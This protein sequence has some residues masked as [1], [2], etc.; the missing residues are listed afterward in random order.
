MSVRHFMSSLNVLVRICIA[1]VILNF[2]RSSTPILLQNTPISSCIQGSNT[3]TG[4][5]RLPVSKPW[6]YLHLSPLSQWPRRKSPHISI[7][8]PDPEAPPPPPP[9]APSPCEYLH[10]SP[11]VQT[12]RLKSPHISTPEPAESRLAAGG[13]GGTAAA[14]APGS[15]PGAPGARPGM[16]GKPG[17]SPGMPGVKTGG[18]AAGMPA[19]N[20]PGSGAAKPYICGCC[21][22][23]GG[24]AP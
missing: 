2:K 17:I 6:E 3:A 8:R 9:A 7:R 21:V 4:A 1:C 14:A 10:R 11:R 18:T 22:A 24:T 5:A 15:K 16:L 12:P 20:P 13:F 19:G 23:A